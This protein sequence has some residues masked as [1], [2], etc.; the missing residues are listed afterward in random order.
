MKTGVMRQLLIG[1]GIGF[2]LA[3]AALTAFGVWFHD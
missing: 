3:L 1:L 2:I